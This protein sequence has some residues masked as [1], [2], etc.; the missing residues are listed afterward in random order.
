MDYSNTTN[1]ELE[2]LVNNK[3]ADAMCELADRCLNGTKGYDKNMNRA[4]QLLHKGEKLGSK[5]AYAGLA[6]MYKN[7]VYFGKSARIAEEYEE[8][9]D[10]VQWLGSIGF[11]IEQR[12]EE[13][14]KAEEEKRREEERR[15][16]EEQKKREEERKRAE[17]HRRREEEKRKEEERQRA[18]FPQ[19]VSNLLNQA[20]ECR[21]QGN[22]SQ[23]KMLCNDALNRIQ[24][25]GDPFNDLEIDKLRIRAHWI[26]AFTAFNEQNLSEL[27]KNA[28]QEGVQALYPWVN[29]LLAI[30]HRA[31]QASPAVLEEDLG[32][33]MAV[34]DN[35]NLS[36]EERGDICVM[37]GDL[38]SE[39]YGKQ[40]GNTKAMAK[41]FYTKAANTGNA[42][43]R[44]IL[45][46]QGETL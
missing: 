2:R 13:L 9:A 24:S 36:S 8:K 17:E 39:G 40:Y 23:T 20:E 6:F 10:G 7:G 29:Y 4:Y 31:G 35:P 34:C 18:L 25:A 46:K 12:E 22:Y 42:Y 45:R 38:F 32:I 43:A 44:E 21:A 30:M 26:L 19:Q 3:D 33:C 41:E 27:E 15:R 5:K 16:E 14:R 37:A 28:K 1:E 11:D